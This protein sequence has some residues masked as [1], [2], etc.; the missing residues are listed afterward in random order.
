MCTKGWATLYIKSYYFI[1]VLSICLVREISGS[2]PA[3]VPAAT[4][5]QPKAAANVP[6]APPPP[7][8]K[9]PAQVGAPIRVPM[10]R[11]A[12]NAGELINL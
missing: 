10:K 5:L 3:Q 1:F 4:P 9:A 2:A 12:V 11:V 8:P 7:P 6:P